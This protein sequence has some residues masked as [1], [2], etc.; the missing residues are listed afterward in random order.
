MWIWLWFGFVAGVL[1][2]DLCQAFFSWMH[3]HGR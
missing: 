2:S 3:A 1:L